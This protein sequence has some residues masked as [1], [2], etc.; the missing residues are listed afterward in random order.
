VKNNLK[1]ITNATVQRYSDRYKKMGKHI[2]TLGWGSVEQQYYRFNQVHKAIS[3]NNK[4][5]LDIGC[6]FA[7][8]LSSCQKLNLPIQHYTGWDVNSDFI[9]EAQLQYP[10]SNFEVL[11]LAEC[12]QPKVIAEVAVMLGVLNL[13]FKEMY[14]NLEYSKLMIKKAFLSVSETLVVDFLSN[15]LTPDYPKE[16]FVFY[17]DPAVMLDFALELTPNVK[18][19]HDYSPIPQKEFILVLEHV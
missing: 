17:H 7:D 11:S 10:E 19:I 2:H 8:F 14:D 13:H 16:D 1:H 3:L 9:A 5:V 12:T 4:T 18:L 15:R 6:G